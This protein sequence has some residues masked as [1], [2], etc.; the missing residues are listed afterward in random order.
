M[1]VLD[2]LAIFS[3]NVLALGWVLQ[4]EGI[5]H[6][7][8]RVTLWLEEGIEV[9]EGAL[10]EFVGGHFIE[11]HFE[12]NLSEHSSDLQ[13]RVQMTSLTSDT[14]SIE[15]KGL[16]LL[17]LPCPALKHLSGEVSLQ[18]LSDGSEILA[19]CHLISLL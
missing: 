3:W 17:F 15:V 19:L 13:E 10:N 6:V 5:V 1:N 16:E 8:S 12:K 14:L 2:C 18:F 9:P 11:S 4:E 7:S